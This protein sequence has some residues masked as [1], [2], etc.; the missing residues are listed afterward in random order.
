MRR[1]T[2]QMYVTLDG[3]NE[4]PEYPGSGDPPR[5]EVDPVSTEMWVNNW[6]STDTLLFDREYYEQWAEFWPASKR[7]DE[8]HPWY[9]EMSAFTDMAQKVVFSESTEPV[10]WAN[11]RLV[12]GDL[13]EGVA[14]LRREPGKNMALVGSPALV[15]EFVQR[16][17]ID[18]YFLAVF[19]V[20][21]GKGRR[22]FGTSEHQQ[23]LELLEAKS[24]P[25]G[26]LFLHYR[27]RGSA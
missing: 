6:P 22:L 21:L 11:S 15:Q 7:T 26:E 10:S 18:D 13:G 9:R 5:D 23:T 1:V 25:H 20:V 4:F 16:G 2:L 24:F 19:P 27:R 14:R 3:Y 12:G 17:L 8:E